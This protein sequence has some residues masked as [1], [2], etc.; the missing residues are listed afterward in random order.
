MK[1]S[2]KAQ[3]LSRLQQ[4]SQAMQPSILSWALRKTETVCPADRAPAAKASAS[5]SLLPCTRALPVMIR[6]FFGV[7]GPAWGREP[8]AR[9]VEAGSMLARPAGKRAHK[10]AARPEARKRLRPADGME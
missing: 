4:A 8:E 9:A 7:A 5:M 2:S 6:M 1:P 3:G 10:D